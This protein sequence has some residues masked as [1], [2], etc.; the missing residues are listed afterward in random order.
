[1]LWVAAIVSIVAF[2]VALGLYYYRKLDW[3]IKRLTI[4]L[5]KIIH[6]HR[7]DRQV[8]RQLLKKIYTVINKSMAV[9]DSIATYQ[10]LDVLKL[11]FGYGL[12][13]PDESARLMAI[14]V[15]AL[16]SNKPD[17]VSFIL[18][19][20]RPLV[21]QLPPPAVVGAIDQ[22]T[23][24]SVVALKQRQ[25]FLAAKVVECIFFIMEQT[26]VTGDRTVVAAGIKALQVIGVFG[27]R[28]RDTALFREINMRLSLW[29]VANPKTD[30]I[31]EEIANMLTA[32]LHRIVGL[33]DVSL[34]TIVADFTFGM[35]EAE[36]L[37]DDGT[38]IIIE[39][40]GNIAA[41]ACLNVQSPMA[42]LIVDFM[43]KVANKQ[44]S[45]K[46]W[47]KVI[48]ITGRVAKL[49]VS[50]HGLLPAFM[51]MHPMLE[52]G[53]K[54]LW[55]ELKFVECVDELRQQLLFR[56]VRECIT[57][58]AYAAKQDLFG[59]TGQSIV[60]LFQYWVGQPNIMAN[61]K[62]IKKYCQLLLLFWLKNKRA[63]K[64]NM[65][66]FTEFIDPTLFTNMEKQRLGI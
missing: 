62:S 18:D 9:N 51:I 8:V 55:A 36:V 64:R 27:L 48:G 34:F 56:V 41:S 38:S 52:F 13:R 19:A 66:Y 35:M 17:I 40:W 31:T 23:L 65:L 4:R 5:N 45:H 54:L 43:F 10:A 1:M 22:L 50:R 26:N 28:R 3:Q 20:F 24:I 6:S 37:C 7:R 14:G 58:L 15:A 16:N 47:I 33:G 32:W 53:R 49:A 29:L 44:S 11:A 39:E 57:I 42:S 21:R 63:T 2:M 12:V 25:N 61:P 59:S 46:Q 30:D 60:D